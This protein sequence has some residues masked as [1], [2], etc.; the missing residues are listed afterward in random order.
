MT[1][2]GRAQTWFIAN[3]KALVANFKYDLFFLADL[4]DYADF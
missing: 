2:V 3:F 4:T 1:K